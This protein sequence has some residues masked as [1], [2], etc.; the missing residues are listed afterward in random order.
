MSALTILAFTTGGFGTFYCLSFLLL[1]IYHFLKYKQK[2]LSIRISVAIFISCLLCS[3]TIIL[4]D[5]TLIV[6][7][8]DDFLAFL[9]DGKHS[10]HQDE[11]FHHQSLYLIIIGFSVAICYATANFM[12][13]TIIILLLHHTFVNTPYESN[14]CTFIV[15]LLISC[16]IFICTIVGYGY[17]LVSTNIQSFY[18][19]IILYFVL[20]LILSFL[21]VFLHCQKVLLLFHSQNMT[22]KYMLNYNTLVG[23]EYYDESISGVS[24]ASGVSIK[25][26]AR[27]MDNRRKSKKDTMVN[28][29]GSTQ[30]M[31]LQVMIK[32]TWIV[33]FIIGTKNIRMLIEV[34]MVCTYLYIY[35]DDNESND[36]GFLYGI[37]F[38][39]ISALV[40]WCIQILCFFLSFS[41]ADRYYWVCCRSC[42]RRLLKQCRY[43]VNKR[44]S[45]MM[46]MTETAGRQY[47]IM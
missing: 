18:I 25:Y 35:S 26:Y 8:D 19:A 44:S 11:E 4:I 9:S 46:S 36:I 10:Y 43:C 21:L 29:L 47:Q 31:L 12:Y 40:V 34:A 27:D 2:S 24:N 30:T 23:D 22:M 33:I 32:Q 3:Y 45:T 13:Y 38:H 7:D 20:N 37:Y 14:K 39:F 5:H 41:F 42:H 1:L 16:T 17:I 28:H 6:I 15:C